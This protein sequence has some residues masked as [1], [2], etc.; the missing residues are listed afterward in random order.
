[1]DPDSFRLIS[2][3]LFNHKI[4]ENIKIEFSKE[5]LNMAGP[6]T[7][8]IIGPNGTGK[9]EILRAL[10]EIFRELE[11]EKYGEK[12]NSGYR[13]ILSYHLYDGD[14]KIIK[15]EGKKK[16]IYKNEK[17]INISELQ[18]P[19]KILAST[20]ILNDKFIFPK[21]R[22][23]EKQS[24][25]EY[26]G[27]RTQ[28]GA[29]GTRSYLKKLVESII[30]SFKNHFFIES[31]KEAFVFLQFEPELTIYYHPRFRSSIF[32]GELTI[33]KMDDVFINWEK[34]RRTEPYSFKPYKK[35]LPEEKR[36]IVNFINNNIQTKM[37]K[38]ERSYFFEYHINFNEIESTNQI[39]EDFKYIKILMGLDILEYPNIKVKKIVNYDLKD[40]S[41]G[42]YHF[43]STIMMILSRI[44]KN[45]LILIDEPENSFHPN[46]QLKYIEN[47][48]KIFSKYNSC[49]FL[50]ATHSHFMI[51]D[52]QK[53]S[54]SIISLMRNNDNVIIP[55]LH[56]EN[57][58]GWSAE[59]IL[60]NIFLMRTVRNYYLGE[61][62]KELLH[63]ISSSSKDIDR[64]NQLVLK[65]E[66][67]VLNDVDPLKIVIKD[68]KEYLKKND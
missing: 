3:E 15:Q 58:Y 40:S 13:F 35:L 7:T 16:R 33:E 39:I 45:S 34:R 17:E 67:L 8:L 20:F 31:V 41:S 50:I 29:A 24:C 30:N 4:L 66:K 49:H 65:L 6:I 14:Y 22:I 59:D 42:E 47:L 9:S 64:I 60:Y 23:S 21:K 19:L 54:S 37:K 1:M 5:Y 43:I 56:S 2:L 27:I 57:T 11:F 36:N 53:N 46:W 10:I 61:D 51:S 48:K 68:A 18:I 25:Y 44:E 12:F 55:T 28:S 62:I 26:L 63:N 32:T 38:Y 52:L